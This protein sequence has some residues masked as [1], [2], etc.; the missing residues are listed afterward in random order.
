MADVV[1]VRWPEERAKASRL[2][3]A[4]VAVLYLVTG[5]DEA[6]PVT[7]C[8]ADWVRIPGDERD[9]DA[10][11]AALERR[12]TAHQASPFVDTA[13]CLHYRGE[14][15]HLVPLEAHLAAVLSDHFGDLVPDEAL[16]E[17]GDTGPEATR[18]LRTDMTRLRTRLR[19]LGLSVHRVRGRG[20]RLQKSL[21]TS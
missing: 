1:M 11:L 17:H 20:Y 16:G 18:S 5:D 19:P 9:L 3:D 8:L 7:S 6:P 14:Q 10:R 13:G 12:A 2:E 15:V 21:T 4:G